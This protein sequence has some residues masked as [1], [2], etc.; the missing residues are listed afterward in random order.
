MPGAGGGGGATLALE[1]GGPKALP[2]L[3]IGA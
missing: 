2:K 3:D 1:G